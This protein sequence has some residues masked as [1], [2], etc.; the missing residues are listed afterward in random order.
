MTQT[1]V[2]PVPLARKAGFLADIWTVARRALRSIPRDPEA[3]VPAIVFPAFFFTV[4]IGMFQDL[5]EGGADFDFKA[6]QLPVAIIFAVTGISRAMGL[7]LDIQGGYFDRLGMTPV[8]R[9]ALLLGLMVADLAMVVALTI[10]VLVLGAVVGVRFETGIPGMVF[11]VMIA[12]FWGLVFAGF[13]YAI[14]LKTGNPAAVNMSFMIFMPFVFLSPIFVPREAMTDWLATVVAYNPVTYLLGALRAL[15]MVGWDWTAIA[16]GLI[17]VAAV[18][19]FSISLALWTL[20]G[21]VTR[22]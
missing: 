17:A 9:L 6:F 5:V 4:N 1:T 7:V 18:G 2:A 12:G 3:F 15:I 19:L 21:R 16:Q 20:H 8:T 10:P 14:A 11:F 22:H 13:P